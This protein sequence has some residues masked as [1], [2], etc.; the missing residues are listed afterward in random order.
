MAAFAPTIRQVGANSVTFETSTFAAG[1]TL[2]YS[3]LKAAIV[4]FNSANGI[5]GWSN[6][7]L[8]AFLS[9]T[10]GSNAA[11]LTAFASAGGLIS[12]IASDGST[13]ALPVL[14]VSQAALTALIA[15]TGAGVA[16]RISLAASI[17]A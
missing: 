11:A 2:D 8:S 13:T 14:K 1:D 6:G 4:T 5:S 17:S 16:V 9:A 3:A 7:N 15:A 12:V 10:H